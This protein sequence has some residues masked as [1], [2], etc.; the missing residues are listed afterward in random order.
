MTR[1]I[2]KRANVLLWIVQGTLALLF[3]FAGGMK[4]LMPPAALARQSGVPGWFM[5]SI[6]IAEITGG[7]GLVLP[8]VFGIKRG[9]TPLAGVGL[10]LLMVGAT[11]VSF[12]RLGAAAAILPIAVGVLLTA[13]ISGRRHWGMTDQ[14]PRRADALHSRNP[15]RRDALSPGGT[16]R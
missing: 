15:V 14:S 7:L 6:G 9:L 2:G 8:G 13:V 4:Q 3:L 12:L 5:R 11:V 1:I 10:L 16:R